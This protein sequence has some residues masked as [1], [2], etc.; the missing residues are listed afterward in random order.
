M[1]GSLRCWDLFRVVRSPYVDFA[2]FR[3]AYVLRFLTCTAGHWVCYR[4]VC[5]AGCGADSAALGARFRC[6]RCGCPLGASVACCTPPGLYCSCFTAPLPRCRSPAYR[7]ATVTFT[8]FF[9]V[10]VVLRSGF[11]DTCRVMLRSRCWFVLLC[12]VVFMRP[13]RC[14]AFTAFGFLLFVVGAVTPIYCSL[15]IFFRLIP[16][17]FVRFPTGCFVYHLGACYVRVGVAI[18]ADVPLPVPFT[19]LPLPAA[20]S[21]Y[22]CA[23]CRFVGRRHVLPFGSAC[24]LVRTFPFVGCVAGFGFARSR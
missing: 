22:C 6:V 14:S 3:F 13:F 7:S 20:V 4:S 10:A 17:D 5:S 11:L 8:A 1:P 12:C 24:W 2:L 18:S 21:A 19:G 23:C 9:T 15:V 16:F